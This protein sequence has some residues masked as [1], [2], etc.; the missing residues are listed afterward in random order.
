MLALSASAACAKPITCGQGET[1]PFH[2]WCRPHA[3]SAAR[4]SC[5]RIY[6]LAD[7][8]PRSVSV[9]IT[10]RSITRLKRR[11]RAARPRGN[12][13][14]C[15]V[16]IKGRHVDAKFCSV[17]CNTAWHGPRGNEARKAERLVVK[18]GRKCLGCGAEISP[19]LRSSARHCSERSAKRVKQQRRRAR[20]LGALCQSF[21]N[22]DV[23]ERDGW[24]CG[25]CGDSVDRDVPWPDVVSSSLDHIVPLLHGGSHTYDN[26]QLAHLGCNI[27]K[28]A[29]LQAVI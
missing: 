1:A 15:G 18:T 7:S 14:A 29:R 2:Q 13:K 22:L 27:R 20:Q 19:T 10:T 9:I 25:I 21:S 5:P 24:R 16:T 28:G 12:C 23:F 8:A 17:A 4:S 26:V 3:R 6:V 11:S